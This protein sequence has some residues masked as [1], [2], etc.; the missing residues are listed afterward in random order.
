MRKTIFLV[1][2]MILNAA[3]VLNDSM[4]IWF[5]MFCIILLVTLAWLDGATREAEKA[6]KMMREINEEIK[7]A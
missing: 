2:I 6:L 1:C 5:R 4:N 7:N 3:T